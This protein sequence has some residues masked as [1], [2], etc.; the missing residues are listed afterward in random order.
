[1]VPCECPNENFVCHAADGCVCKHGFIGDNCDIPILS[2]S[3]LEEQPQRGIGSV[4][5][6]GFIVLVLIAVIAI[7]YLYHKKRVANLKTEIARVHYIADPHSSPDQNHFDNPV[8]S[9]NRADDNSSLLNNV[10]IR[11]NLGQLKSS[12][13]ERQKLGFSLDDDDDSCKGAYGVTYQGTLAKNRD[14]DLGNPN[15]YHSIEDLNKVEHLY[16]EI[17]AK[18]AEQEYDHLDYSRPGT[19][20]NPHYHRM[21][22]GMVVRKPTTDTSAA[23]DQKNQE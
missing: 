16:D 9:F 3:I 10:Q 17:K 7:M 2:R 21:A 6:A 22:N 8:Y 5:G 23:A 13:L 15:V 12:N 11:N 18:E 19:S 1:M 14:A 4:V 20:I